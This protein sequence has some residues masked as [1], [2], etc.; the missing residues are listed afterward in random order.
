MILDRLYLENFKR[1]KIAEINF[2]NGI[3]GIVGGNGTG[4]SSVVEAI[5][6]ALFGVSDKSLPSEYI[7]SSFAVGPCKVQLDFSICTDRYTITRTF[8]K[9]KTVRHDATLTANG[10]VRASGVSQVDIE[11]R[12]ILGMG[13]V[14]FRNTVYTAQKDRLA[15]LDLT[16]GKRRDWFLRVLGLQGI[17]T[18]SQKALK[19]QVDKKDQ[20]TALLNG[21]LIIIS[22][23]DPSG[24]NKIRLDFE[25]LRTHIAATTI[26]ESNLEMQRVGCAKDL[27][28]FSEKAE[29]RRQLENQ[30]ASL[31]KQISDLETRRKF[32]TADLDRVQ[33][34]D[35]EIANLERDVSGIASVRKEAENH[36]D[37]KAKNDLLGAVLKNSERESTNVTSRIAKIVTQL[38]AMDVCEKELDT[39][40]AKIGEILGIDGDIIDVESTVNE[41]SRKI[42]LRQADLTARKRANEEDQKNL[43]AKIET[44][45]ATG[46]DGICPICLQRLGDHFGD[47]VT[48]YKTRI[49]GRKDEFQI[50]TTQLDQITGELHRF[51]EIKPLLAHIRE[52]VSARGYREKYETEMAELKIH[53][54]EQ[55]DRY[56]LDCSERE[57]LAYSEDC[58]N[59]CKRRLSVL[60]AAQE[61]LINLN[62]LSTQRAGIK[63]QIAEIDVQVVSKST[64]I[65]EIESTIAATPL[66]LSAGPGF[67]CEIQKLDV[68]LKSTR[69]DLA[70]S[71]E[72]ER[73]TADK[74]ADLEASAKRVET[75][76]QQIANL[77]NEIE[78]LKLTRSVLSDYV[79]YLIQ[80]VRGNIET[81]MGAIISDI[82]GGR[83]DQVRLDEDFNLLVRD[84]D[85]DN[86][87]SVG[88][89]SGGEQD[90]IAV[91]LR[92]ALSRYLADLHGVS[93]STILIFDEIFGSQDDEHRANLLTAMSGQHAR[94]P[95]IILISHI[96]EIQGAFQN[97]LVVQCDGSTSTIKEEL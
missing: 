13:P 90:D 91:A 58:H 16:P 75:L 24:I 14:D 85:A 53:L 4:K 43:A 68:A 28:I 93:D 55:Q 81:E 46:P 23:Q 69:Q 27:R 84:G 21:E 51:G 73:F 44:I 74:I 10:V 35:L 29:N 71:I 92:I 87:F 82:T 5:F 96:A 88:R 20:E 42:S 1:F 33:V 25:D 65:S 9:G 12:R 18:G 7:V 79:I 62:V 11:I 49:S 47:V 59:D 63:A 76:K 77:N 72:R 31:S 86:E 66:D 64:T 34:D 57:T 56:A 52:I 17:S 54:K 2:R 70:A 32:L 40:K 97:T 37:K 45:Q 26:L 22:R 3:T 94:F 39:L 41:Y 89:F 15:L 67:E 6:F 48:D 19:E 60:D 38:D 95:Q 83:Y 80:V 36:R 8:S 61:R 50:L 78:I 30:H